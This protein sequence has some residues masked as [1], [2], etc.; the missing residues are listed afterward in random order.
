MIILDLGCGSGLSG[1]IIEENGHF[2]W[3][4]DISKDMLNIAK[5]RENTGE[6]LYGDLGEGFNF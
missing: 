1:E 3:G 6:L 5:N 4:I 2:W